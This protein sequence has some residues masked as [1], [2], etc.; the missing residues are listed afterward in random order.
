VAE[1]ARAVAHRATVTADAATA[2]AEEAR[3]DADN[4]N[5]A[6]SQFLASM[7]HELRTPLNAILGYRQLLEA[8]I[9]GPLTGGQREFL[10]RLGRAQEHLLTLINDVLQFAKLEAGQTRIVLADVPVREVC[11]RVEELV[12]PQFDLKGVAYR[13][14]DACAPLAALVARVDPERVLQILINLVTNAGKFTPAGGAVTL[15][16]EAADGRVLLRVTDSGMGIAPEQLAV[17]FEPFVQVDRTRSSRE[18][19]GLGLAIARELARQM[20][21]DITA[22]STPDVGSVF[23]VMLPLAAPGASTG[24]QPGTRTG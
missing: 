15:P 18:G 4:A 9:Q 19:V 16:A 6:K 17:V 7:S 5:R 24:A 11:A 14:D 2:A 21:G 20:G 22:E 10:A 1:R 3:R 23:T 13:C 12:R 8:E